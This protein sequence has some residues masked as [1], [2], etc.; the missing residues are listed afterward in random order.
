MNLPPPA[1]TVFMLQVHPV[2]AM[3]SPCLQAPPLEI[4]LVSFSS[5]RPQN[6]FSIG[7]SGATQ[8][9]PVAAMFCPSRQAAPVLVG[10]PHLPAVSTVR[11]AAQRHPLAVFWPSVQSGGP[12]PPVLVGV[13]VAIGVG[14]GVGVGVGVAPVLAATHWKFLPLPVSVVPDGQPQT[15]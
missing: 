4:G 2:A 7:F 1:S 11:G 9:Q 13:G 14:A 3:S 12:S 6:P 5:S 8:L 15:P 10:W